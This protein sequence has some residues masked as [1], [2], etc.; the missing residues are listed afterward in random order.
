MYKNCYIKNKIV[1]FK[2]IVWK[3]TNSKYEEYEVN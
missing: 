3:L 2:I 1:D